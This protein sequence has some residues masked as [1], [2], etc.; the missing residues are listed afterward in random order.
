MKYQ[1][2]AQLVAGWPEFPCLLSFS[3][4]AAAR[5][6]MP[7]DVQDL[8]TVASNPDSLPA[9]TTTGVDRAS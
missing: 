4:I 8:D 3:S 7:L 6:G 2:I 1:Q 9:Q 5:M